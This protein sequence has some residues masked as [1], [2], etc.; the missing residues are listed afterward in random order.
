MCRKT[1]L[2][3]T[4]EFICWCLK[5]CGVRCADI[6]VVFTRP[7]RVLAQKTFH[8]SSPKNSENELPAKCLS[9]HSVNAS[10]KKTGSKKTRA[11]WC[12][13]DVF[14]F[15]I[16]L[17]IVSIL[18]RRVLLCVF[19]T[20]P[21]EKLFVFFDGLRSGRKDDEEVFSETSHNSIVFLLSGNSSCHEIRS[22]RASTR[23]LPTLVLDD[24][25]SWHEELLDFWETLLL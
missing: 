16:R 8:T 6:M 1:L 15:W 20:L 3:A 19:W 12:G 13:E 24:L 7:S 14:S 17:N 23:N 22:S 11:S 9:C 2:F 4:T 10:E 5:T 18:W 21:F 25:I